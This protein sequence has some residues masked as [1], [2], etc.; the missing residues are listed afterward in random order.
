M[1]GEA[2]L[3]PGEAL[4]VIAQGNRVRGDQHQL[5]LA[6]RQPGI[7]GERRLHVEDV[8]EEARA[9]VVAPPL[10]VD[11][12]PGLEGRQVHGQHAAR[13]G[14]AGLGLVHPSVAPVHPGGEQAH[15]LLPGPG[16]PAAPVELP[17]PRLVQHAL[18]HPAVALGGAVGIDPH[19]EPVQEHLAAGGGGVH[20]LVVGAAGEDRLQ[21]LGELGVEG[22]GGQG[23]QVLQQAP[24]VVGAVGHRQ[25]VLQGGGGALRLPQ[26]QQRPGAP[27][28]QGGPLRGQGQGLVQ[29]RQGLGG[30]PPGDQQPGRGAAGGRAPGV[31]GQAGAQ[32]GEDALRAVLGTVSWAPRPQAGPLRRQSHRFH[33]PRLPG[34]L[35]QGRPSGV[36]HR[37]GAGH[38]QGQGGPADQPGVVRQLAAGRL[39]QGLLAGEGQ[40]P[41]ALLPGGQRGGV[42]GQG[43]GQEGQGPG[44]GGLAGPGVTRLPAQEQGP[45]PVGV[46]G[47]VQ[48]GEPGVHVLLHPQGAPLP[49]REQALQV[50]AQDPW[51]APGR[52]PGGGGPGAQPPRRPLVGHLQDGATPEALPGLVGQDPAPGPGVRGE[53]RGRNPVQDPGG[54]PLRSRRAGG[55]GQGR[56]ALGIRQAGEEDGGALLRPH[57]EGDLGPA[58]GQ[59]DA[60]G[61]GVGGEVVPP[62]HGQDPSPVH[63]GVHPLGGPHQEQRRARPVALHPGARHD[64]GLLVG[65]DQAPQA[66]D[67]APRGE[68][69]E[70]PPG[71]LPHLA[72]VAPVGGEGVGLR[73]GAVGHALAPLVVEGAHELPGAEGVELLQVGPPQAGEQGQDHPVLRLEADPRQ[74]LG[75]QGRV[76]QLG[77]HPGVPG[78]GDLELIG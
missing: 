52:G 7:G 41:G 43:A 32:G 68:L 35:H 73:R 19:H 49:G 27:L 40:D 31:L 66:R 26:G 42:G 29:H 10:Q 75:H 65:I 14:A 36:P 15:L 50:V 18:H 45:V 60:G 12:V 58:R 2:L 74:L 3:V 55:Q 9:Q 72:R 61:V 30:L 28:V 21:G 37:E 17:R 64:A 22:G 39:G 78:Q 47:G 34:H 11:H 48:G 54:D 5:A 4:L 25:L 69:G 24:L 67:P 46:Q 76:L 23:A 57:L 38:V 53:G 33:V 20:G 70:G 62:V 13:A 71:H 51:G 8:P 16:A 56:R 77:R 1:P 44:V 6:H 63:P 59:L